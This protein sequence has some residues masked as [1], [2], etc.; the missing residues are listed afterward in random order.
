MNGHDKGNFNKLKREVLF[1]V[2][3]RM[4]VE[5]GA[6]VAQ[7]GKQLTFGLAQDLISWILRLSPKSGSMFSRES[8]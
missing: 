6:W 8:A 5:R 4:K 2:E 3:V 1:E 7:S